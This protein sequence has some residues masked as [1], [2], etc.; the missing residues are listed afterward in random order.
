MD[1]LTSPL[2][3]PQ[4]TDDAVVP[5]SQ[6][7]LIVNALRQRG[8]PVAYLLFDG[9]G[10]GFRSAT[11]LRRALEAEEQF[12]DRVLGIAGASHGPE[13]GSGPGD[14]LQIHNLPPSD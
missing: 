3:V 13:A 10:H 11:T 14:R 4:G 8:V 9:E 1:R 5:P 7:E 6:S 2:P 12:L